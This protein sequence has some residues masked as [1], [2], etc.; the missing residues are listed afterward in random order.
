M[1]VAAGIVFY[2]EENDRDVYSGRRVDLDA[3][4]YACKIAGDIDRAII[5]NRTDEPLQPFDMGMDIQ[6]TDQ[7]PEPLH[8]S[9]VS[10]VTPWNAREDAQSLWSFNHEVDWYIFGPADGHSPGG[11]QLC[12]P[13]AGV[14]AM[15]SVHVA[16][17]VM[18]HRYGV[19][20][21]EI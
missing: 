18:A 21:G 20:H 8:G 7:I 13:Q 10:L 17:V 14:G 3:W 9:V 6:V 2:F 11:A 1:L 15:H 16:G 19:V 4:N 12:I 5:I